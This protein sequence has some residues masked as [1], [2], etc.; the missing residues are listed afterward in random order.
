MLTQEENE[1]ICRVGPGTPM[2]N[3]FREYWL[4]A[5]LSEE[6]PAADGDPLRIKMLGEELIAFRDTDGKVGLLQNNCPH[7]GASL[8]F[9]RN[10]EAGIRCVYH[11]WKFD[12]QG[13]CLDMPNE[14]A[15]SDFKH[16]VKAV[17]YPTTERGGIVWAY[18]GPRKTP[19]SL[20]DLEGNMLPGAQA[21][22]YQ[23]SANWFQILEGHIDTAHVSFLHYGG[24]QPQDVPPNTFSEYQLQQRNAHFEVID[25]EGGAAYAARRPAYDGTVYW[26]VAQWIF[27]SFSMAPPGV[28]G[29]GKRNACEVPLDDNHTI[30]YQMSVARGRPG[31]NGPNA[32]MNPIPMQPRTTDWYGRWQPI[33]QPENDFLIDRDVQRRNSGPTGFTGING[34]AMQD[35]AVT[36]SMG[37]IYN[38]TQEH[39]GTSDAMVIRVRRRVIAAIQAHLRYGTVPPGVDTPEAYR[40]R[41]GGVLLPEGADWVE[42]TREL[43]QAFVDHKDLDPALNGPL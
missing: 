33:V 18:L 29:L 15:E 34:I 10:E 6:L 42:A 28:L 41:S 2:G 37:P 19:P 4:P 25:T 9:G 12:T 39:L 23:Q 16:K 8:F 24:I 1:L 11:G 31:G 43:R 7:R 40:V 36:T 32:S 22:A 20:P 14:P 27:P 30:T 26:R 38:R 13:N 35:A 5:L 21:W 3:L 17:A